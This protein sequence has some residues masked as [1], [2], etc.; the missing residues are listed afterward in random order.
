MK[1]PCVVLASGGTGGH[2]F[3]ATA[4]AH[5]LLK[6]GYDVALLTDHRGQ[7]YSDLPDCVTIIPILNKLSGKTSITAKLAKVFPILK[8]A[9]RARQTLKKLNP[10]CVIGLGGYPSTPPLLAAILMKIPTIIHEQNS[11]L[12]QVNRLFAPYVKSIALSFEHTDRIGKKS[13]AKCVVTGNP[14]R[15]EI[16]KL[17]NTRYSPPKKE[18]PF[19]LLVL[20]GSQG[21]RVFSQLIPKSLS[22]MDASLRSR[23]HLVQQCRE[24]LLETTCTD[25]EKLGISH[26]IS[27][28]FRDMTQKLGKAHLVICRAGASSVTELIVTS[29]PSIL[30]PLPHATDDH[31]TKNARH[32][33]TVGGG[34]VFPEKS[35]S[36]KALAEKLSFLLSNP[37]TLN[38]MSSSLDS[39][40]HTK[41]AE[42]LAKVVDSLA[43]PLDKKRN[44]T[45]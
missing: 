44:I 4:L 28:F 40:Q 27:P 20:G 14:V 6:R 9:R 31:Q 43:K 23:I 21:A 7:R 12:G 36:P 1:K 32:I 33:E 8:A 37:A 13:K 25:I 10:V 22:L 17:S 19:N 24:E 41:A 42:R 3:P 38:E 45:Y 15:P 30:V 39:Q 29:R 11:V 35:L 18:G 26:E 16:K 2:I 34:Y 5:E